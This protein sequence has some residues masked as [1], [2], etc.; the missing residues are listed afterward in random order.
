[1]PAPAAAW[2]SSSVASVPQ[3]PHHAG[4]VAGRRDRG[5]DRATADVA[6]HGERRRRDRGAERDPRGPL[7]TRPAILLAAR[8]AVLVAGAVLHQLGEPRIRVRR[9]VPGNA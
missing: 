8:L 6:D 4:T 7:R 2:S 5:A 3:A 9:G 1:M